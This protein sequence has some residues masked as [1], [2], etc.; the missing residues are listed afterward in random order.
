MRATYPALL[1]LLGLTTRKIL[2]EK[3]TTLS[4][5][6]CFPCYLIPLRPKLSPQYHIPKHP[7]PTSLSQCERP[8]FT[9]IQNRQN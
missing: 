3:Y 7:Q 2:R 4:P 8:S 1:I 5:S 9:S 6:L